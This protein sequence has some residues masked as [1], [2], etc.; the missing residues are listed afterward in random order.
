MGFWFLSGWLAL[1][2]VMVFFE[3]LTD[4]PR[5]NNLETSRGPISQE[6]DRD[7]HSCMTTAEAKAHLS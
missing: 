4:V 5:V 7:S 3:A 2:H 1:A 6:E